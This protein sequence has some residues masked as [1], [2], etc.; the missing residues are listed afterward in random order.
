LYS[1]EHGTLHADV[2]PAVASVTG[3]NQ[4][5]VH[6]SPKNYTDTINIGEQNGRYGLVVN[7]GGAFNGNATV[8]VKFT[9]NVSAHIAGTW[10][11]NNLIAVRNG[12]ETAVDTIASVPTTELDTFQIGSDHNGFNNCIRTYFQRINYWPYILSQSELI[13]LTSVG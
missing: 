12:A 7:K 2:I 5:F 13:A 6:M 8:S 10:E 1:T 4:F 9:A 3:T 11:D